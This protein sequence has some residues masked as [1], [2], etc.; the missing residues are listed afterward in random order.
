M[1]LPPLVIPLECFPS[2]PLC[3]QLQVKRA[4]DANT[5]PA[6]FSLT[7]ICPAAAALGTMDV[8]TVESLGKGEAGVN[9]S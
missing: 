1:G 7:I 9:L 8:S 2:T 3:P 5:E 6:T 4:R